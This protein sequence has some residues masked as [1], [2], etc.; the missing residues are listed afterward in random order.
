MSPHEA[1]ARV[2]ASEAEEFAFRW[3]WFQ[4][5]ALVLGGYKVLAWV[6]NYAP[7]PGPLLRVDR[8]LD[9]VGAPLFIYGVTALI[10]AQPALLRTLF[11]AFSAPI[12][13]AFRWFVGTNM[14][15][16]RH[17]TS[18]AILIA[19]LMFA[20]TL[21]PQITA[22]SFY[23][24]LVR[25]VRL[26]TGAD[27]AVILDSTELLGH[28]VRTEAI[29]AQLAALSRKTQPAAAAIRKVA[30]V[31]AASV[32]YELQ[33]PGDF[34]LPGGMTNLPLYMVDNAGTYLSTAYSEESLGIGQ[35][36]AGSM[37]GTT[38]GIVVSKGLAAFEGVGVGRAM[39]VG[40]GADGE[41]EDQVTGVVALLPGAPQVMLQTRE[42]VR[43]RGDRV[44]N[45]LGR[46]S[47]FIVATA[48]R[49]II[50]PV[51]TT[52][53]RTVVLVDAADGAAPGEVSRR[54]GE[55]L[56]GLGIRPLEIKS[57][58]DEE[59]RLGKDM[60]VSL[61]LENI[62]IYLI[63][64][65]AVAL[66]GILAVSLANFSQMRWT[67]GLLRIRGA[68][69]HLVRI[70][71]AEFFVPIVFGMVIGIT[72]G[73]VTGYGMTNQMFKV[74]QTLAALEILPVHLTLTGG[75]FIVAPL[76]GLFF[77]GTAIAFSVLVFRRTAREGLRE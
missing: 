25:G 2:S 49:R 14:M 24:K 32:L 44:L 69:K 31:N 76:L 35:K 51:K 68:R 38:S 33:I 65:I 57:V 50:L 26:N 40:H 30:G 64:G 22:D 61:G 70:I 73:I 5:L 58:G 52:A 17:R 7:P 77:L 54:I 4:T 56:G 72:M 11:I 62:R 9:F 20:I 42:A 6:L 3:G 36:F 46:T 66:A 53:S 74:P 18:S 75:A 19:A 34:Y 71:V 10:V 28:E 47:P 67:L 60:F 15:M 37:S 59:H 29:S 39:V 13:G 8:I 16:R 12:A 1:T 27:L 63:G 55:T 23:E 48:D 41:V 21:Y 45:L 43:R